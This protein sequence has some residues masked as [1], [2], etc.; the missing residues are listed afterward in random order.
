M[1][2]AIILPSSPSSNDH[3]LM[4]PSPWCRVRHP[5]SFPNLAYV[6]SPP[7]VFPVRKELLELCPLSAR[8]PSP[9]SRA[10]GRRWA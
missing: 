3:L 5:V 10:K 1:T 6:C 8:V 2:V 7:T 4:Q 9:Y